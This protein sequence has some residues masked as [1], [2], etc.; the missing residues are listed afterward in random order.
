MKTVHVPQEYDLWFR[1]SQIDVDL[2]GIDY[3]APAE[4][5]SCRGVRSGGDSRPSVIFPEAPTIAA[6]ISE[7]N[8]HGTAYVQCLIEHIDS[9]GL[10]R[11]LGDRRKRR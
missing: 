5:R 6:Y 7:R 1:G 9:R 4:P 11:K 3:T 8:P 2:G 10:M